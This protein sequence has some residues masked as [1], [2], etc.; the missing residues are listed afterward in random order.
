MSRFRLRAYHCIEYSVNVLIFDDS[1][2]ILKKNDFF[3]FL[4]LNTRFLIELLLRN[5]RFSIWTSKCDS[6][7]PNKDQPNEQN[8]RVMVILIANAD[9]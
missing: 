8:P 3:I 4:K 1:I 5:L 2:Y 7:L 6:T 9:K